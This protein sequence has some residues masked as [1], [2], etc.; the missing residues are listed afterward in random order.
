MSAGAGRAVKQ[1]GPTEGATA[2]PGAAGAESGPEEELVYQRRDQILKLVTKAFFSELTNYGIQKDEILRVA[3]HLLD[4][5]LQQDRAGGAA[6]AG[7][8]LQFTA[9][10]VVDEWRS[11]RRLSL[12][13]VTL[14]PLEADVVPL[15]ARWLRVPA[16]R[17]SFVVPFPDGE[18]DLRAFL[19]GPQREY[20][21]IEHEGAVV[22]VIGGENIDA[23]SGKLEM[24]KLI[25]DSNLRGKGIGKRATFLFLHY[26]FAIREMHKVY[27]HSRDINVRNINL[28]SGF[29][30]E[31]EGMLLE[32]ARVGDRRVDVV[33]MALLAPIWKALFT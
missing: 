1:K 18:V 33:R 2:S 30:F 27:V 16:I 32:D 6:G 11:R 5:V 26:A 3:S 20:F 7:K 9:G 8:E 13:G 14:R 19:A 24:K 28:N 22:G 12:D 29:G 10:A 21:A 4:N 23:A 31:L 15:M 17:D 25:G